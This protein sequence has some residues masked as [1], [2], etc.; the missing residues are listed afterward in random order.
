MLATFAV[1][2]LN[3]SGAGSLRQAVID[4]N[5]APGADAI[6]FGIAGTI[7]LQKALPKITGTL[8]IDGTTAPGYTSVPVVGIDF[9]GAKG[10]RFVAGSSGSAV[11]SLSLVDA[12]SAAVKLTG[13]DQLEIVGNYIGIALNGGAVGNR[14]TGIDLATAFNNTIGGDTAAERNVIS[15]N[16]KEGIRLTGSSG[17]QIFGNYIGTDVTGTLDFGNGKQGIL[18]KKGSSGNTIGVDAANLIS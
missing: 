6:S 12:S 18:L 2:T 14:G 4:A 5:A 15:A 8:D 7:N 17:N 13:V 1:T 9:N 10:L 16:A 3:D 11:Q